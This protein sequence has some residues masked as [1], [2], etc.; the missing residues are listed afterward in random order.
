MRFTMMETFLLKSLF[1]VVRVWGYE[2]VRVRGCGA[3]RV[4]VHEN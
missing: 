4:S 2:G 3:V 1:D